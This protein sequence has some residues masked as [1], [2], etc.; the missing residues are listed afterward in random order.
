MYIGIMGT[1]L[2]M[3][4]I[5]HGFNEGKIVMGLLEKGYRRDHKLNQIGIGWCRYFSRRRI[6]LMSLAPPLEQKKFS[7]GRR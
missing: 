6:M 7:G 3:M 1:K 5:F 2:R 4:T